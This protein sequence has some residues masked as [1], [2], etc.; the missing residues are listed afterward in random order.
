M[1]TVPVHVYF[2]LG[3]AVATIAILLTLVSIMRPRYEFRWALGIFRI[4]SARALFIFGI[5]AVVIAAILPYVEHP[6]MGIFNFP[7]T[8]EV[9][10]TIALCGG[11]FGLLY[12]GM[13]P[14]KFNRWNHKVF[15]NMC[16]SWIARANDDYL[17]ALADELGLSAKD[18]VRQCTQYNLYANRLRVVFGKKPVHFPSAVI[19]ADYL[20]RLLSDK[21]FCAICVTSCPSTGF[22]FL[23][24]IQTQQLHS[25]AG[26]F[27]VKELVSQAFDNND[28]ILYREECYSG[29][30]H[31]GSFRDKVF[32]NYDFV[33]S[34]YRPLQALCYWRRDRLSEQTFD[35]YR[36][37]LLVALRGYFKAARFYETPSA[38]HA[39]FDVLVHH[40]T[41]FVID[42][43]KLPKDSFSSEIFSALHRVND[44]FRRI[45][46]IIREYE[47]NLPEYPQPTTCDELHRDTSLY[48]ALAEAAFNCLSRLSSDRNHDDFIRQ[49]ALQLWLEIY[50]VS[51]KEESKA[52]AEIQTRFE[53]LLFQKIHENLDREHF[54][55][56]MVIRLVINIL[57]ICQP[58][59]QAPGDSRVRQAV[60]DILKSKVSQVATFEHRIDE[61][62]PDGYKYDSRRKRIIFTS[63][64]SKEPIILKCN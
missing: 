63:R 19:H 48:S 56:P 38:I 49:I 28:S 30:G 40:C 7:L 12:Q 23:D 44:A 4:S 62:L 1:T 18:I 59:R 61:I 11:A 6:F 3:E 42:L 26:R 21:R 39:A 25:S 33:N 29:L 52:I 51:Q 57:G 13:T 35:V 58:E 64:W 2:D 9:L 36:D 14:V 45:F 54:C 32:G 50:P 41:T 37:V 43:E 17:R 31:W 5:L 53:I 27:F 20:L 15:F 60:M 24:E 34:D 8:W 16:H 10:A 46:R 22:R 55:Y 47:D